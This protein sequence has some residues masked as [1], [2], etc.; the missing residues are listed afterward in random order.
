MEMTLRK[1]QL[2]YFLETSK[3]HLNYYETYYKWQKKINSSTIGILR[4]KPKSAS[5]KPTQHSGSQA[6][7]TVDCK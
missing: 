5:F 3:I 7:I 6:T 2:V 1:N 4:K